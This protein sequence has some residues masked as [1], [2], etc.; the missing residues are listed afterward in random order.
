MKGTK[1][2][3]LK[4][5]EV[6]NIWLPDVQTL[7]PYPISYESV[8]G[9]QMGYRRQQRHLQHHY[10]TTS[11]WLLRSNRRPTVFAD[12]RTKKASSRQRLAGSEPRQANPTGG[13]TATS[14]S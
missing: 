12:F 8:F 11:P 1:S 10:R 13:P 14:R 5:Q 3:M 2:P 7:K 4:G 6:Y 9:T